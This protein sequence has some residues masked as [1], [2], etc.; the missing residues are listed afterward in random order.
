M[1]RL[2]QASLLAL[3]LGFSTAFAAEPAPAPRE[4]RNLFR[5]IL[6]KSDAEI[7][8]KVDAAWKHLF[9][10]DDRSERVYFPVGA[11]LGRISD[12]GHDDVR[13]EGVSYGMMIAVQLNKKEEFDR[14]WKWAKAHMYHADGPRRGYFAWQCRYDGSQID[15]GSASDG[16]EWMATALFFASHRWGNGE[17]VLNYGAEAQALLK[18]MRNNERGHGITAIFDAKHHQPVFV[19]SKGGCDFTDPSYH[20]PAFFELWARWDETPDGRE[21]WAAC[22]KESREFFQRHAHPKTGLMSEYSYFDGRP[23]T[24]LDF[25]EG[26]GDFRYDACRVMSNVALD[27][28]WWGSNPWAVEQSNRILK[29]F[30][31]HLPH[32]PNEFT[33]DGKPLTDAHSAGLIA[34]AA[35]AGLVSDPEVAKPFVEQ[36]WKSEIPTGQWRYYSGLV[37]F[38]GLLEVSGNFHV[39]NPASA[40]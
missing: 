38:L 15:P 10:G 14:I 32:I 18:A 1:N 24:A 2:I 25:G 30:T 16:E 36:L 9:Y 29:F 4:S 6:G 28:A 35:A 19:P 12:V 8:A 20:L 13:S 7:S 31:P 17:G 37:Y 26:K 11:D 21:F 5:E 39:Y 34:M 23:Y 33:L 40:P 22:V 3:T 27:H